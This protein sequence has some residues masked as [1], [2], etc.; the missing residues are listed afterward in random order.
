MAPTVQNLSQFDPLLKELYGPG[1]VEELNEEIPFYK[2]IQ[3]DAQTIPF[4]GR[5]WIVPIHVGRNSGVGARAEGA[6]IPSAGAQ[7]FQDYTLK[8]TNQYGAIK[9]TGQVLEQSRTD[10]GAFEQAMEMEM[11]MLK[12]QFASD[13]NFQFLRDGNGV[14]A[15]INATATA[16]VN[17]TF[18]AIPY[19]LLF[20]NIVIDIYDTTL[21]TKKYSQLSVVSVTLDPSTWTVTGAVLSSAVTLVSTDVI[22]RSGNF[23]NELTGIDA[24]IGAGTYGGINPATYV[25][26]QSPV[27]NNAAAPGTKRPINYSI[28]QQA[29]D[30]GQIAG[31]GNINTFF[32]H[33]DIR[34]SFFLYMSTEKRVVNETKYAGGFSVL[35]Y[36]GTK[37]I[38]DRMCKAN[39]IYGIDPSYLVRLQTRD[40][41]FIDDDGTIIHRSLDNTDTYYA[42]FRQYI[43]LGCT[44]RNA[45][46][47]ITDVQ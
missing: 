11:R 15:I 5:R 14:R 43:N 21:V 26:W 45:Q 24:A 36:D 12:T 16:S 42:N 10:K 28:F 23:G 39:T 8:P 3:A 20:E 29:I 4:V 18:A 1:V 13:L 30:V 37:I 2:F 27:L 47:K 34:R 41:H 19:D 22:V 46:V 9:I 40:A 6:V 33:P 44:K 25:P 32:M 17:I 35:E 7:T 38:V 31:G